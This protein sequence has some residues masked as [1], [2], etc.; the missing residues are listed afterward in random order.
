[1]FQYLKSETTKK[2]WVWC[3]EQKP[4]SYSSKHYQNTIFCLFFH[5]LKVK[6]MKGCSS[7]S[8]PLVRTLK[9]IETYKLTVPYQGMLMWHNK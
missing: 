3:N 2:S 7:T 8:S 1:M 4:R 9:K 6:Q 5:H